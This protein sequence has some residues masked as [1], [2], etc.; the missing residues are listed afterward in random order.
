MTRFILIDN[1]PIIRLGVRTLLESQSNYKVCAEAFSKIEIWNAL[2]KDCPDVAII[3]IILGKEDG[4]QLIKEISNEWPQLKIL[5]MSSQD[6]MLYAERA[7]KAGALGFISQTNST[8]YL[9]K[10]VETILSGKIYL[11][12]ATSMH[13]LTRFLRKNP[14]SPLPRIHSLSDRELFVYQMI[15]VGFTTNEI[16]ESLNLSPKTIETYK[17]HLKRKLQLKDAETLKLSAFNWVY[18][19]HPTD[20]L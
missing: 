7:I 15:G 4:L 9:L 11:A 13:L 18:K 20:S 5:V 3:D 6:E 8:R 16:A 17:G 14:S 19:S 2:K 12:H 10:A 1:H